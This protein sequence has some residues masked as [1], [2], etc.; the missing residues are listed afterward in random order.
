MKWS[1][2]D[3]NALI[4]FAKEK[5]LENLVHAV[6][7]GETIT[8]ELNSFLELKRMCFTRFFFLSNEELIDILRVTND[9]TRIEPHLQKCFESINK[10]AINK[11]NHI[12]AMVSFENEVVAFLYE[13][14]PNSNSLEKWLLGVENM[15]K[16]SLKEKASKAIEHFSTLNRLNWI[17]KYPEQIILAASAVYTTRQITQA[18]QQG[19]G[20]ANTLQLTNSR[21]DEIL[22]ILKE[23]LSKLVRIKVENLILT[24]VHGNDLSFNFYLNIK[25]FKNPNRI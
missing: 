2:K 17:N 19:V 12:E 15:M 16:L 8:K 23:N 21:L 5:L 13:I 6:S 18:I 1:V 24:D 3:C 14:V 9:L 25:P 7:L 11:E 22:L 4:V 10:L 20:L